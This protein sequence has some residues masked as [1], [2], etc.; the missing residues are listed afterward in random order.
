MLAD[1]AGQTLRTS[2]GIIDLSCPDPLRVAELRFREEGGGRV[3]CRARR[4]MRRLVRHEHDRRQRAID[5]RVPTYSDEV[6]GIGQLSA[7]LSPLD[8]AALRDC[9]EIY[10][11]LARLTL[12]HL[13]DLLG[14]GWTCASL[15]LESAARAGFRSAGGHV[16]DTPDASA[17][18]ARLNDSNR[19]EAGRIRALIQQT[20]VPIDWQLDLKSGFRWSEATWYRD[21]RYGDVRGADVKV[22]WELGRLQHLP[23]LALASAAARAVTDGARAERFELEFRN[24]CLDFISANPPRFGVQWA[25]TMDVAIRAS[26]MLLAW[27][28]FTAGGSVFDDEFGD[29]FHRSMLEHGL[30]I[31]SNLEWSDGFRG[32][33]YLADIVGLLIV[34][35][36]LEP[37]PTTDGWL[38]LAARELLDEIELQFNAEGSNREGSTA[39]HRLSAEL[40]TYGV[41]FLLAVPAERIASLRLPVHRHAD[42]R[43]SPV[44]VDTLARIGRARAFTADI[45]KAD[46]RV[47]QIGDNDNGRLF[48]LAPVMR[49][50]EDRASGNLQEEHLD[51][52]HLLDAIDG[53]LGRRSTEGAGLLGVDGA[54]VDGLS[55]P[56]PD[57]R[58]LGTS[59]AG[60]VHRGDASV[61]RDFDGRLASLPDHRRRRIV[62]PVSGGGIGRRARLVGYPAFGLYVYR[63]DRLHLS[64]RCG[65]VGQG[66]RGGHDHNDQ[67]SIE[68]AVDGEDW[69]RDPG[70]YV[71]TPL[72]DQRNAY[73]SI[74]AHFA[75]QLEGPE[76]AG[77]EKELFTLVKATGGTCLY[78]GDAGFAGEHR[79]ADGRVALCRVSVTDDSVVVD[80]GAEGADLLALAGDEDDWRRFV[81]RIPYSPGYGLLEH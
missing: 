21:I 18:I 34:A 50:S 48:K 38:A 26:N 42:G 20:Y 79:M 33:H 16:V 7:I 51:H 46:G 41:A 22:P 59:H 58:D 73:R 30:H 55:R 29:V 52:R 63:S 54:I 49:T 36:C 66:G 64:V 8:S 53:L 61:W 68:L 11:E 25:M 23:Q 74:R 27:A 69:I 37:T 67:L 2:D 10:A 78:W 14:S 65:P 17:P 15:G 57:W 12:N 62:I 28:L 13:F 56:A 45:M 44:S 76:P 31:A 35:A 5:H 1:V 9:A 39:Y 72:P 6:T 4:A 81:P 75:P 71:Y 40:A 70:T 43:S 80:H 77:L 19:H 47:P 60:D 32:N 24:Q 3:L